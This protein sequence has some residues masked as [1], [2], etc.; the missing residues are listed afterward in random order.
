MIK[1]EIQKERVRN[2][3]NRKKGESLIESLI[4]MF[5]VVAVILPVSDIFLKTYKLNIKVNRENEIISENRN[6]AEL[7]KTKTYK[8][9]EGFEGEYEINSVNDFYTKFS[10]EEKYRILKDDRETRTLKISIKKTENYYINN[11]GEKEY[12]FEIQADK[13]RNFYFPNIE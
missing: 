11:S 6:M 12:I 5:F 8:E 10:I 9:I 1:I 13:I 7:L 3:K 4:S 2:R